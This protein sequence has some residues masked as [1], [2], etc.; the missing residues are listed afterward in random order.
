MS[1]PSV[2]PGMRPAREERR[3]WRQRL[4]ASARLLRRDRSGLLG[5]VMVL[6]V[7]LTALFAP[8][9]APHDPLQ[10]A[11]R[12]SK[13]PP[14]WQKGGNP[15]F[16]LGTDNLGR[17]IES[18]LIYGARVSIT[19]A[20]FGVLIAAT[21]G[22]TVGLIAGY[23][24]GRVDTFLTG[25]VNL[26]LALPYLLFVVFVAAVLGRSLLNVILIF[27]ITDA[28]IFARVSRGEVL[29][30]KESSHVEA[31]VSAGAGQ[32][33]VLLKTHPAAAA[34][35]AHHACDLR[36]VGHDLLRGGAKFPWVERASQRP[37]LGQHA[38]EWPA[39]PHECAVDRDLPRA[40]HNVHLSGYESA[41]G[42]AT[43]RYGPAHAE[44]EKV[45]CRGNTLPCVAAPAPH[46][47]LLLRLAQLRGTPVV[48][49][50]ERATTCGPALRR[51]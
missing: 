31:A 26:L 16:V 39:V 24:G 7:V 35:S 29:R 9:L 5:F 12:F 1:A 11:L 20:F 14:V 50:F 28:P 32:A 21:L 17:D 51:R 43:R 22:M 37:Q 38:G 18:R 42:L 23:V 40:S 44:N 27:G 41:G 13:T 15:E 48:R 49:P 2:Q 10:Q 6:A 25:T 30:L 3:G 34:R 47:R 19:V 33:R 45:K 8:F 4:A 46:L 36:D